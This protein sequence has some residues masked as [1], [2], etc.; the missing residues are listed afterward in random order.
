V[1]HCF[2]DGQSSKN[3]PQG[4]GRAGPVNRH[5]ESPHCRH[6]KVLTFWGGVAACF[7]HGLGRW[8]GLLPSVMPFGMVH[9]RWVV[10]SG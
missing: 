9:W 8:L 10:I 7:G 6:E 3:V 1:N 2:C 4:C 5:A